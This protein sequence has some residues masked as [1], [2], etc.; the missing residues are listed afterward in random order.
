ML[1]PLGGVRRPN[2]YTTEPP[3][4]PSHRATEQ[5]AGSISTIRQH[6]TCNGVES[7][8]LCWSDIADPAACYA[9]IM[10]TVVCAANKRCIVCI[11]TGGC[12]EDGDG[13]VAVLSNGGS[14]RGQPPASDASLSEPHLPADVRRCRTGPGQSHPGRL[15]VSRRADSRQN[16]QVDPEQR[17][18]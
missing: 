10:M 18:S 2:H 17:P 14:R 8:S 12:S 6:F 11:Y 5:T 4:P 9:P 3:T 15:P 7:R 1:C 13:G 16:A